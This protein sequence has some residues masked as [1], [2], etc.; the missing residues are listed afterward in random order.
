MMTANSYLQILRKKDLRTLFNYII[1]H[2]LVPTQL[3]RAGVS[4]PQESC[5][6][7]VPIPFLELKAQTNL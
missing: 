1:C 6:Y 4:K 3:I 7:P 5:V 2:I